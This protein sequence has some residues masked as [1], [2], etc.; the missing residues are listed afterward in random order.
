MR[1]F[2]LTGELAG[3]LFILITFFYLFRSLKSIFYIDAFNHIHHHRA[4]LI[5]SLGIVILHYLLAIF[6]IYFTEPIDK[7]VDNF[8]Y[9]ANGYVL[10]NR[11][12]W[13]TVG[14]ELYKQFLSLFFYAF[15]SS[16]LLLSCVTIFV[17]TAALLMFLKICL[18]LQIKVKSSLAILLF[19]GLPGFLL[20]TIQP[21]REIF[22]IYFLMLSIYYG[23]KYR[24]EIKPIY[25]VYSIVFIIFFGLFHFAT[26][27]IAPVILFL[28]LIF[29]IRSGIIFNFKKAVYF[30]ILI[31]LVIM[32]KFSI[33]NYDLGHVVELFTIRTLSGYI[34][35][36]NNHKYD[37]LA[38]SSNFNY[39]WHLDGGSFLGLFSSFFKAFLFYMFKPFIWEISSFSSLILSLEGII[40][41]LLV[42]FSMILIL[43][44]KGQMKRV[45]ILLLLIYIFIESI[46][47]IGTTN[48]GTASRHHLI[49]QWIVIVLGGSGLIA[50]IKTLL[51]SAF[52][53]V[54]N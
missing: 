4:I 54:H 9:W 39:Y 28:V 43:R 18:L 37:L 11:E 29:P 50:F 19:G 52:P 3:L 20:I 40:R 13:I 38:V 6:T 48:A 14:A 53:K 42:L 8:V 2:E 26:M 33:L 10:G 23:L 44:T 16:S 1:Y 34:D 36:I 15:G 5:S 17:F 24:M 49:A 7:D 41:L 32:V 30:P 46:M 47:A 25:L 27:T 51:I 45:Y 31:L 12:H 21:Y 35:T 22:L